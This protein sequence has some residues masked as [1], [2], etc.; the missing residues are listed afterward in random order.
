ME[1]AEEMK[2]NQITIFT[3]GIENG[4]YK[5]LYDIASSPGEFYSYLLDSFKEFESLARKALHVGTYLT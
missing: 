1:L 3:V 4:N 5:E 2:N